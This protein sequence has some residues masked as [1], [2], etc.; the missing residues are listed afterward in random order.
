MGNVQFDNWASSKV[1][2][3]N[4]NM[5]SITPTLNQRVVVQAHGFSV[6]YHIVGLKLYSNVQAV[7]WFINIDGNG[8]IY[9]TDNNSPVGPNGISIIES[10]INYLTG[11]VGGYMID[12]GDML[13]SFKTLEI[14]FVAETTAPIQYGYRY[15]MK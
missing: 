6:D 9:I 4:V 10:A 14:G 2:N 12:I 13:F 3:I 1:R 5:D 8:D 15:G 7:K 11:A